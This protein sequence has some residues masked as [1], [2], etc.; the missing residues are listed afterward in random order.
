[1]FIIAV[2]IPLMTLPQII[3]IWGT[4]S[5][6]N[7]SLSTWLAYLF[8]AT[9]WLIHSILTRNKTLAVNQILWVALESIVVVGILIY[10]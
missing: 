2:V 3:S 5:A 10:R 8:S 1:M 6:A 4:R 7:V 9:C